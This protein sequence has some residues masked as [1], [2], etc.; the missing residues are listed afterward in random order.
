MSL[1]TNLRAFSVT[2]RMRLTLTRAQVLD[3]VAEL[4]RLTPRWQDGEPPSSEYF[5]WREGGDDD[6]DRVV[7]LRLLVRKGPLHYYDVDTEAW[8]PWTPARWSPIPHP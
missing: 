4:D 7:Q 2:D 5:V 1:L 8:V 3:L 6:V